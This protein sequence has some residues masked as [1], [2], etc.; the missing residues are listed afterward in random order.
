M[1]PMRLS[2]TAAVATLPEPH[3]RTSALDVRILEKIVVALFRLRVRLG[4]RQCGNSIVSCLA[5]KDSLNSCG[6]PARPQPRTGSSL[7][8]APLIF[9]GIGP[10]RREDRS[11]SEA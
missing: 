3:Y 10:V 5:K 8:N 6:G 7:T 1:K 9:V 4:L 2:Q 11:H